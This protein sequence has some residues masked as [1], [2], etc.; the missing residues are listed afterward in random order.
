MTMTTITVDFD[1]A[2][3]IARLRTLQA[4]LGDAGMRPLYKE[5][6]E[7]I[8]ESTRQRFVS[9]TAPDGSRWQANAESTYLGMLRG[10]KSSHGKDGRINARGAARVMGKKPLVDSGELARSITWQWVSGGVAIG[11]NRFAGDWEAGAAVHQFGSRDGR[12]PARPFLGLSDADEAAVLDLT[13]RYLER[14]LGA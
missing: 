7:V 10:K 9:G 2:E 14:L 4:G 11:T 8:A 13:E 5:I 3:L 1:A 6:G 12:V